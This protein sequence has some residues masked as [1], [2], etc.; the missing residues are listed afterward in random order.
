MYMTGENRR[1]ASILSPKIESPVVT[2]RLLIDSR[3]AQ[4][5]NYNPFQFT[6]KLDPDMSIQRYKNIQCVELK[7]A[8]IPK[9]TGE[10]YV[11]L[12]IEQLRD[13]NLDASNQTSHEAFAVVY[14]DNSGLSAGAYKPMDKF[15][16]QKTYFNPP[17]SSLDRLTVSIKKPDGNV[18]SMSETANVEDVSFLLD[19]TMVDV[20]SI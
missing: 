12:D 20:K 2:R 4:A 7:L 17:I 6:I 11:V 1:D 9:V 18:V 8:S 15:F 19:V 14:F 16:S 5:S 3:D 13:S 10:Q